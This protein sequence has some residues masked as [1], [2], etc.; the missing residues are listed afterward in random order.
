MK[1]ISLVVAASTAVIPIA[2]WAQ[3]PQEAHG[4]VAPTDPALAQPLPELPGVVSWKTL[5]LV[6][7]VKQKDKFVPAFDKSVAVLDKKEVKVQGFMMPLETG[8]RQ[9]HFILSASPPSCGF[10]MPGG[11]EGIVEVRTK[12]PIKY[13]VDPIVISGRMAILRDDPTGIYYRLTDASQ[14]TAK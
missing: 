13:T 5:S 10:C 1:F 3:A 9:K 14:S 2:T 11:P 6:E 8:E 12:Q 7:T 4:A